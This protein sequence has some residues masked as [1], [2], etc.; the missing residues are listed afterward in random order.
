MVRLLGASLTVVLLCAATPAPPAV[1]NDTQIRQMA[2][3]FAAAWNKHDPNAMAY[4]WS[5]DGDLINPWGRKA[6]GLTEIQRLFQDEHNGPMKVSTYATTAMSIRMLA[7]ALA[8]VDYDAEIANVSLPDG[9]TTTF[10]PHVVFI[11]RKT[12]GKWWIVSAR[13]Y[14]FMPPPPPPAPK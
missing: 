5:A 14:A 10:K 2:D 12:N 13:P 6:K 9:S 4:F 1:S 8:L 7:P 3:D 11:V